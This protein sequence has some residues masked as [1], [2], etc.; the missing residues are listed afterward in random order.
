MVD[1]NEKGREDSQTGVQEGVSPFKSDGKFPQSSQIIE[2]PWWILW[3]K[4]PPD[5]NV[6]L[7]E[8]KEAVLQK[9][10]ARTH[11]PLPN[12]SE[13]EDSPR[14]WKEQGRNVRREKHPGDQLDQ[15]HKLAIDL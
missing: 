12:Q 13:L 8:Q 3:I 14:A 11:P 15:L 2:S 4:A 7:G 10:T 9:V 5:H 6:V 1:Q